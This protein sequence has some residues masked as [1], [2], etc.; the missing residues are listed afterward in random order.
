MSQCFQTDSKQQLPRPRGLA[1]V[2]DSP[3]DK[4]V[5]MTNWEKVSGVHV[6]S[7]VGDKNSG[8]TFADNH[9]TG[10]LYQLQVRRFPFF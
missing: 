4:K 5:E 7:A 6:S 10:Q 3:L 1:T 2:V 9:M 8:I